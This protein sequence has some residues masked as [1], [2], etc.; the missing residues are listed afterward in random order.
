MGEGRESA[1]WAS[2]AEDAELT[3][4]LGV[5]SG[6]AL[7][8]E[9]AMVHLQP[10]GEGGNKEEEEQQSGHGSNPSFVELLPPVANMPHCERKLPRQFVPQHWPFSRPS[11][12]TR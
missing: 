9:V 1:A 2:D 12:Y 7:P 5:N 6:R 8:T 10:E 11:V 4:N 3:P